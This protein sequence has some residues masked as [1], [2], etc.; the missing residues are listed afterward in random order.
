MIKQVKS[1]K[2]LKLLCEYIDNNLGW[3]CY[4]GV[5]MWRHIRIEEV[6]VRSNAHSLKY[7]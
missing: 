1:I 3:A 7:L 2:A 6:L 4:N 5:Q